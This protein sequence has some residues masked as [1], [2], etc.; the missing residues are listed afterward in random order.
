MRFPN[1][2]R[3]FCIAKAL[4]RKA[5][6]KAAPMLV[7]IEKKDGLVRLRTRPLNT[8]QPIGELSENCRSAIAP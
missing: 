4:V 3:T 5:K 6:Q 2:T 1:G 7:S 8:I